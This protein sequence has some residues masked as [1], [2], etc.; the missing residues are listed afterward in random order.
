MVI[1]FLRRRSTLALIAA[2]LGFGGIGSA[3]AQ[4]V[5]IAIVD[6]IGYGPLYVAHAQ[7][8]FKK[9]GVD[10]NLV[11]FSD[12][13]TMP[14]AV[15]SGAVQGATLTY[16]QVIDADAKGRDLQVV[17]P[18][19][20]SDGADAVVATKDITHITQLKGMKVAF[21]PLSPSAFLIDYALQQHHLDAGAIDSVTMT[22]EQV[23]SAMIGGSVKV[24][25]TYQP[26]V[27]QIVH[28][29]GGKMFHVL[30][31][32]HQAPG[33]ITD[34]LV[35]KRGYIERHRN[36]VLKIMRAYLEGLRFM[37]RHHD[38][39]VAE[40]AAALRIKPADVEAQLKGV[41]NPELTQMSKSFQK[42]DSSLSLY[43]SGAVISKVF[44]RKHQITEQP[45]LAATMDPALL[46]TLSSK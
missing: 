15:A 7:G 16:D 19:D 2:L 20:Y 6:W 10:V 38:K 37:Q 41:K 4:T 12:N 43:T 35:F 11:K 9:H 46:K 8:L 14:S 24:G 34:V 31:S 18:I 29:R 42:S 17:M 40:M 25:V 1:R 45:K 28:A 23:A 39:A 3:A 33:L 30:Y 44:I 5:K 13:S 36:D 27:S 26:S 22:P 21:N 32:S